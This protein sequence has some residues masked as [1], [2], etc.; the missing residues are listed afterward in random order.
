MACFIFS[1]A[2]LPFGGPSIFLLF[3]CPPV[4][5]STSAQ[6]LFH[7][8]A[9]ILPLIFTAHPSILDCLFFSSSTLPP[10]LLSELEQMT[11]FPTFTDDSFF[12]SLT[13]CLSILLNSSLSLSN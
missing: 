10:I 8:I 4:L 1:L 9:L 12:T 13:P 6:Y 7:C 3:L 11:F 2:Y 5:S